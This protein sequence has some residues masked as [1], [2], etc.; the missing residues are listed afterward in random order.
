MSRQSRA[1]HYKLA[2]GVCRK[3]REMSRRVSSRCCCSTGPQTKNIPS[4]TSH[5]G[6]LFSRHPVLSSS[7][8]L[9]RDLVQTDILDGC[10]NNGKTAGLRGE[11]IN[12]I[13]PLSHIAK[14]TFD[15]I[16]GLNMAMHGRR[17]LVKRQQM[18]FILSQASYRFPDSTESTWL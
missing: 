6:W 1:M 15:S 9:H 4:Q 14:Q 5:Y 3:D 2:K 17:K 13:G 11:G 7:A 10:P 18:L 16:G 8:S 12:L